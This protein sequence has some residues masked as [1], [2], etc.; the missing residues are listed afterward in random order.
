MAV[1]DQNQ[2]QNQNQGIAM[3]VERRF[4]TRYNSD[5]ES[6][7]ANVTIPDLLVPDIRAC[8]S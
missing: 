3:G 5:V 8:T 7:L 2:N 6:R 4:R 1:L